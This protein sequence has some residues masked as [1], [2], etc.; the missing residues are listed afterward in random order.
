MYGINAYW[1]KPDQVKKA[2]PTGQ[3]M[4]KGSFMIE[5][6]RNFFKVTSLKLA[7]GILE[8]DETHLLTCGPPD[9]IKKNCICYVVI[10]PAG[11]EMSDVAKKIKNK[12]S[13]INEEMGKLFN[14]DDF[15]RVLPS[16]SSKITEAG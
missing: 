10:E 4:G 2:A 6:Q 1:V 11:T 8:K 7:I 5:G 13:S 16:G 9:T 3:T 14:I 15:V 12:F